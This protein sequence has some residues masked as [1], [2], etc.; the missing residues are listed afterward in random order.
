MLSS[1]FWN[2]IWQTIIEQRTRS[3]LT[4]FGVFWGI[5]ILT[6]MIGSGVGLKNGIFNSE[7]NVPVNLLFMES[8]ETSLSYRGNE[9][10]R[11]WKM[12]SDIVWRLKQWFPKDVDFVAPVGTDDQKEVKHGEKVSL[13]QVAGVTPLLQKA[14]PMKIMAGR[15]INDIDLNEHRQ[16]CLLGENVAE[17]L[18]GSIGKAVGTTVEVSG[19]MMD[20]VGVIRKPSNSVYLGFEPSSSVLMPLTVEQTVYSRQSEIDCTIVALAKGIAASRA[21]SLITKKMKEEFVIHPDDGIALSTYTTEKTVR[22]YSGLLSGINI[23][24]WIVGLGTLLAGL[25]GVSNIMLISVKERTQEIGICRALGA[26]PTAIVRQILTES[27]V[28]T[29]VAGL[30]GLSIGVLALQAI[31]NAIGEMDNETFYHPYMPF[32]AAVVSLLVLIGGG[33]L[34]GWLPARQALAM[35]LVDSLKEE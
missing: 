12:T 26:M 27:L 15:F 34:A 7:V 21:E 10:G 6:V 2:D 8:E 13:Y 24:I 25:V 14:C 11:R 19:M 9:S 16:V 5:F 4:A 22:L 33:L 18:Y 35:K 31:S 32:W 3:L 23:L 28:L 1:D 30:C 20:V 17:V 29:A